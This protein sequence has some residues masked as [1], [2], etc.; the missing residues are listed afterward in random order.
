MGAGSATHAAIIRHAVRI[1]LVVVPLVADADRI[2]RVRLDNDAGAVTGASYARAFLAGDIFNALQALGVVAGIAHAHGRVSPRNKAPAVAAA[3]DPFAGIG[4]SVGGSIRDTVRLGD[5]LDITAGRKI[6]CCGKE[7]Q[8]CCNDFTYFFHFFLSLLDY[9]V[10]SRSKGSINFY[11]QVKKTTWPLAWRASRACGNRCT[12][13]FEGN[14]S[15]SRATS[16]G[17]AH[18]PSTSAAC[19]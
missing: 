3:V 12:A 17:R 7:K 14:A 15:E 1:P 8:A 4:G 13:L 2:G 10:R 11:S 19:S 5:R 16:E 9:S 18:H 6:V